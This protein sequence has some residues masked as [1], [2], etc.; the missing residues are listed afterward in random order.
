MLKVLLRIKCDESGVA[1]KLLASSDDLERIAARDT[2]DVPALSGWRRDV[3]G[4]DA[5]ALKHGQIALA[6]KRGQI[7]LVRLDE[8]GK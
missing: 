6:V 5:L 4:N 8:T 7:S 1:A 3:F 2:A